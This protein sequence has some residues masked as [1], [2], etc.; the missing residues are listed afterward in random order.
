MTP[1]SDID[2]AM[3]APKSGE[4][5]VTV[6]NP[7]AASAMT[8]RESFRFS[9]AVGRSLSRSNGMAQLKPNFLMYSVSPAFPST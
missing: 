9:S 4:I 8:R 3:S 7:E 1:P 2:E 6:L 5:L